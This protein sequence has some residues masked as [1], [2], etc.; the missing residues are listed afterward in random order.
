MMIEEA[1]AKRNIDYKKFRGD[2]AEAIFVYVK[3]AE[4]NLDDNQS[5]DV[6][7]NGETVEIKSIS[8]GSREITISKQQSENKVDTY[9]VSIVNG[10]HEDGAMNIIEIAMSLEGNASFKKY[11]L[12][13]YSNSE[14]GSLFHYVVNAKVIKNITRIVN[15]SINNKHMIKATFRIPE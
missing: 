9:A 1:F 8:E 5:T 4:K 12:E 7:Y 10:K 3:C 11:L 2:L 15:N 14:L 6:K 13:T